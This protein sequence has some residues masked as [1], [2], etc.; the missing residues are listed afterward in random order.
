MARSS[1][2]SNFAWTA[3]T[4]GASSAVRFGL[5]L[6]LAH[7]LAPEIMGM[8]VVVN[9]VRLGIELLT[10]V[11]IEQNMI[12]HPDALEPRFRD[13]AWT[14]QVIRGVF[15]SAVFVIAAPWFGAGYN[16]DTRI[17]LLAAC[18][19]IINATHSTAVFALVKRLE[20]RRRSLFELGVDTLYALVTAIVAYVWRTGWAPV[21][22]IV[23][24]AV[25][26]SALSYTLPDARQ[27]FRL[28][29]EVAGRI[30][31]FGKWIAITTLVMYAASN[32]DRLYLGRVVPLGLLGIYGIARAIA[33]IPTL[34]AR[35]ISYQ[36]V[37]PSLAGAGA[38]DR[39]AMHTSIG[40]TRLYF[41]LVTCGGLAVAGAGGDWLIAL[42]YDPRYHAAGW[43]LSV[44]LIGAIFA[45][46]SNLN[47]ALLLAGG[48]PAYSTYANLL[49]LGTLAALMVAGFALAG[50][51]GAVIAVALTEVLQFG[52][53]A[54]G[55]W[56]IGQHFWR[57]DLAAIVVSA[58]IFAGLVALRASLGAGT[59]FALMASGG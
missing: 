34:L 54:V 40:R 15:L 1:T 23:L 47:E 27:R 29:R 49:R 5:N 6:L 58:A 3:G 37:F 43:M 57:Q 32:I 2:F 55:Q 38:A 21:I 44:L 26:R 22:G 14:L 52:Y 24:F 8:L 33:D 45:I 30:I 35:R 7:L 18:S 53:I 59:P 48:R 16:I 51:P 10:D 17:F 41:V 50:M 39:N 46:L 13:T 11:G 19:P 12:H 42:I 31:H 4:I 25:F 20:V 56:R 9:S 36:V 28:D